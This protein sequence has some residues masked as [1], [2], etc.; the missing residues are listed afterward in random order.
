VVLCSHLDVESVWRAKVDFVGML[1]QHAQCSMR[2]L[3]QTQQTKNLQ[4]TRSK[5]TKQPHHL[6]AKREG[7]ERT[8]RQE[9]EK[10]LNNNNNNNN[11]TPCARP[12]EGSSTTN[13]ARRRFVIPLQERMLPCSVRGTA[14]P[15]VEIK[16]NSCGDQLE[17]APQ[18][19]DPP[20]G[21]SA[22]TQQ[23]SETRDNE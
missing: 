16:Q 3:T 11:N 21:L 6:S 7:A 8:T 9:N 2:L 23:P 13:Q 12:T 10:H 14:Q 15:G 19:L 22:A 20:T 17:D 5:N 1:L 18:R 4:D